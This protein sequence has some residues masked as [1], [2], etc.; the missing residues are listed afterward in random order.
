MTEPTGRRRGRPTRL[1]HEQETDVLAALMLRREVTNKALIKKYGCS[2][3]VINR[4]NR[5]IRTAL[6]RDV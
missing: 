4:L 3:G 1:T 6:S 2:V 5:T